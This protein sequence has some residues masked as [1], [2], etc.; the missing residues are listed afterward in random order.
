MPEED[1]NPTRYQKLK[2]HLNK[3]KKVYL[4]GI[5]SFAAGG[6]ILRG[7]PEI[8][9]IIGSFNYRSTITNIVT[10]ELERRG[11]PGFKTLNLRTGEPAA[12]INRMAEMDGVSWKYVKDN[13]KGDNPIYR[14]LGEMK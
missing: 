8:K 10:T 1:K 13:M 7:G 5:G 2:Q 11:H 3:N 14:N 12:S 6:L 4:V 9:Q